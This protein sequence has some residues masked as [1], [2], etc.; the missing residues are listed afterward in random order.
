[1]KALLVLM[2]GVGLVALAVW[3]ALAHGAHG[4]KHDAVEYYRGWTGYHHPIYL[5]DKITKEAADLLAA[6]GKVYLVGYFDGAGHLT[7]VV[8]MLR[9]SVFFEFVYAYDA[10]GKLTR[11]S[12]TDWRGIVTVREYDG[13][14]RVGF[15]W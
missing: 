7:R 3:L 12:A 6:D 2:A 10:G 4:K 8:K 13:S 9:G 1:M 15:F 14:G 5:R 11:V